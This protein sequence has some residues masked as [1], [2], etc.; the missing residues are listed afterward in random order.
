MS[1][2]R[3][4]S[5]NEIVDT[6]IRDPSDP[7]MAS[8]QL[9]EPAL[10]TPEWTFSEEDEEDT[11]V[12]VRA[13]GRWSAPRPSTSIR[14]APIYTPVPE[15]AQAVRLIVKW[16]Y[17]D[18]LERASADLSHRVNKPNTRALCRWVH[19]WLLW[20]LQA[21]RERGTLPFP[22]VR[23]SIVEIP[24]PPRQEWLNPAPPE[25]H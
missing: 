2:D 21:A 18:L 7:W 15:G 13:E 23:E 16:R 5:I 1:V 9:C 6:G 11:W 8:V 22:R 19:R 25:T 14:D 12:Q 24:L 3:L 4:H 10:S 17:R 20:P